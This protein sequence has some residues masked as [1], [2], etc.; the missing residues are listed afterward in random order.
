MTSSPTMQWSTEN[1]TLERAASIVG[2]RASLLVL[3]EI[4]HGVRRFA[5]ILARTGVPR[6][7]LTDRLTRLVDDG[8]LMRRP[9]REDGQRT[10]SEYR[11]TDKGL[12][13]IPVLVALM[14]WG[15]AYAADDDGP[16][17][18]VFHH[19]CGGEVH[20]ALVCEHGHVLE[21]NRQ[22]RVR[23]GPGARPLRESVA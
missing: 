1:C 7:V 2:D 22:T 16:P 15:N 9:Y 14:D 21:G 18:T 10:R 17:I 19:E 8:I 6:Q 4:S 12:A 23:P 5:D 13:L 11:F 3:R 20:A